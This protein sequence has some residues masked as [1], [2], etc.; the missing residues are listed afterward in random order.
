M[1]GLASCFYF[2]SVVA[3]VVAAVVGDVVAV[4][5]AVSKTAV[6]DTPVGNHS[7]LTMVMTNWF[8]ATQQNRNYQ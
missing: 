5:A 2:I 6:I 8:W 3:V 7:C 4:V 1:L